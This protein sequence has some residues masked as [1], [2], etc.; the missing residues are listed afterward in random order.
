MINDFA[1]GAPFEARKGSHLRVRE[2]VLKQTNPSKSHDGFRDEVV[3]AARGWIGTPYR[4]Q[5]SLKGA[6]CDCLGLVRGVWREVLGEEPEAVPAYSPDWA[7]ASGVEALAEAAFRHLNLVEGLRFQAGDVV[8]FRW[9]PHLPAKH[10]GIATGVDTMVHA[11][12]GIAV[13]EVAMSAWWVRRV[14]GVYR[15]PLRLATASQSTS[16]ASG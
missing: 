13:S 11:Q 9:K 14:A 15:F 3:A 12:D 2:S 10:A 4:H 5:A 8:L 16:P 7:E 1:G 6:G